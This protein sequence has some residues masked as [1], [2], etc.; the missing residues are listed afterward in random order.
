M[1]KKLTVNFIVPKLME[2]KF[3]AGIYIILKY[4]DGLTKKGH[5]VN[6]IPPIG[7]EKPKWIDCSARFILCAKERL[8]VHS[9][10]STVKNIVNYLDKKLYRKKMPSHKG[11]FDW[12]I[13][14][15]LYQMQT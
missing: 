13:C 1:Q 14:D 4:A 12:T 3:S 2:Y 10:N 6:V 8:I 5:S 9:V 11:L 15:M 7:S